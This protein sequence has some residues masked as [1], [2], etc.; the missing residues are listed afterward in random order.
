[1]AGKI[2]LAGNDYFKEEV[3][4]YLDHPLIEFVGEVGMPEKAVLL[5]NAMCNLHPTGFREPFGLSILEAAYCG[6]PTIAI[7]RGSMSELIEQNRTG[8][9]V[10]DFDEGYHQIEKCFQ[11]DRNYIAQRAR[12]LFNYNTMAKQYLLAYEKTIQVF[13]E[14]HKSEFNLGGFLKDANKIITQIWQKNTNNDLLLKD[15][16]ESNTLK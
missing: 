4:P 12:L 2:D 13:N 14:E 7:S 15:N 9:L 16:K 10:E 6:T 11:M 8:M 3:E 1:M 5:S